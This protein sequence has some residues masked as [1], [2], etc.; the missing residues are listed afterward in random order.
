MKHSSDLELE[1][2]ARFI[3]N[4]G[5]FV[6][7]VDFH[8]LEISL[9]RLYGQLVEI[10]FE[11]STEKVSQIKYLKGSKVNPYLKHLKATSLN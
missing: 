2:K 8:N 6:S 3:L 11:T 10:W 5:S 4:E 7:R 9:Y 1:D